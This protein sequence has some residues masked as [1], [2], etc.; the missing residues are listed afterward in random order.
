MDSS[1]ELY[2]QEEKK[3]ISVCEYVANMLRESFQCLTVILLSLLLPLSFIVL[4]RLSVTQY[5]IAMSSYTG[6]DTL[7][8]RLYLYANP[9]LLHLLAPFVSISA[10]SQCLTGRTLSDHMITKPLVSASWFLLFAFQICVCI[11]VEGSIAVGIDGTGFSRERLCLLTRSLFFLGLHETTLFWSKK[12]VKPVVD[13]TVFGDGTEDRYVEKVAMAMS[14]GV[15]WW[16]KL[17]DEVE[18]L[19]VVVEVKRDLIGNVDL[20]D[21]VGWWLY[22]VTVAIG[23]VKVVKALVWLNF[24]LFC[25]N[26]VDSDLSCA[27]SSLFMPHHPCRILQ[28]YSTFGESDTHPLTFLKNSSNI[29]S[30]NAG[31][32]TRN[33]NKHFV[34]PGVQ[35]MDSHEH[36]QE[37]GRNELINNSVIDPWYELDSG[38]LESL[39]TVFD[40]K[41]H[42]NTS[43]KQF[44]LLEDQQQHISDN[45]TQSDDSSNMV[46]PLQPNQIQATPEACN[47][48]QPQ[49]PRLGDFHDE[50]TNSISLASLELLNNCGR[51]FKKS[52]EENLS[53]VLSSEARVSNIPK[54]STEEILRIAGERYIQ[55]S[56]H[57]VDGLS[58]FIHP[59]ASSLTGL[60]IEQT[61]D[62]ELVHLLLAAAEEVDQQQFHLA[63]QSIARCLWKASAKGNPIQR[64]FFYF[65]EALQERIDQEIGRSPSFERK[66]RFLSTLALGTTPEALTCHTE[67]PFSQVMQFAGIQAIFENIKG[68]TKI[69]LVDFN[70]RSGIQCTGLM[71]ALAEQR[72]RPIELLKI[73]AIGHQEK[74]KIEETGKRLQSFANSLNLPFSFAMVFMSD[75]KDLRA[76]SVNVKE[77]EIVAV[78]C[79]TVL[80]T[81]ICRQD[82]LDNTMRRHFSFIVFFLIALRTAWIETIWSERGLKYHIGEGIRNMVTAEG[83]E[84]FTR[85]VKLHE[86]RA[87]IARFRMVEMEVSE[88]SRY[89]AKLILEQFSHGSS[90]IVQNDGKALQVG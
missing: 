90:C 2:Q 84:R 63:S 44:Q 76:E 35:I 18:S 9:T 62:M 49:L 52:S 86:W 85:N 82:Y 25:R 10:L 26:V 54:L 72:D 73:T 32:C 80:R 33:D 87:Y 42:E 27:D 14:F 75:M 79:S 20:V 77:H 58:M 68:A 71:Q 31:C 51:L 50:K 47:V 55:Y 57:R 38:D 13:D 37:C 88:S 83:A 89:Q 64:L 1:S 56:T 15:L 12:V 45:W 41:H 46:L 5:L 39:Y 74:E 30:D 23:M 36:L 34:S 22:Y 78:Y 11:G 59:Y 81:M 21:F 69:H 4:A 65:G 61:K 43:D 67:I 17:R 53:N 19:V 60:S 70:I 29:D 8:V 3:V 24:V 66:L 40:D 48:V 16:C 28:K 7:L 6:P